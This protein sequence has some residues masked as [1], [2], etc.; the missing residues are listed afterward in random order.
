MNYKI[1]QTPKDRLVHVVKELQ[2]VE[3]SDQ[4]WNSLKYS[5]TAKEVTTLYNY[6]KN[7]ELVKYA[8]AEHLAARCI[9]D[10]SG[11]YVSKGL[12][13]SVCGVVTKNA[14]DWEKSKI[15]EGKKCSSV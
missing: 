15:K 11:E 9:E 6:F 12:S 5:R 13:W 4:R 2:G 1:K 8:D 14:Y 3:Y 7:S 10:L